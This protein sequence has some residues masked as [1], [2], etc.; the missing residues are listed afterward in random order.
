APRDPDAATGYPGFASMLD[1]MLDRSDRRQARMV[2]FPITTFLA[3]VVVLAFLVFQFFVLDFVVA[4]SISLLMAPAQRRLASAFGNRP[5][6]A[7]GALVVLTT[8]VIFVPVLSSLLILGNQTG[9]F[10]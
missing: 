8:L 9:A 1:S 2:L 4:A 6:L 7:A 10:L 5:S 3:L